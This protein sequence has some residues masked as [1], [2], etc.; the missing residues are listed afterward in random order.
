MSTRTREDVRRQMI[1]NEERHL[2]EMCK[3]Y[4]DLGIRI[5]QRK[6]L[7]DA[8]KTQGGEK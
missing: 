5:A 3:R 6:R 8:L 2:K 7:L 4:N 1:T